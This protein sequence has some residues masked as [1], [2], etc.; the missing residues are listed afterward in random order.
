MALVERLPVGPDTA[1][2]PLWSTTARV[3]VSDVRSDAGLVAEARRITERVC[4][5]VD[6]AASRFRPD[7]EIHWVAANAGDWVLVSPLL[8]ELVRVSLEAAQRT[9][10]LVDPTVADAM[11]RLGYDR[12]I[13]RLRPESS[14]TRGVRVVARR[15]AGWRSVRFDGHHVQ[16]PEGVSLDLGATAKAWAADESARQVAEG[17]G[18]GV[19]VSLGGD[20]ATA[21]VARQGH[22][23]IL[24]SDG[25]GQPEA[26]V[27]LPAGHALATSST[28]SRTWRRGGQ[29]MHH[30]LDPRT[31]LPAPTVWR[32]VS[33]AAPTCVQAN[34]LTTAAVVRGQGAIPWLREQRVTARLVSAGGDVVRVGGWP[35]ERAA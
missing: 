8:A 7:A 23:S 22:W 25:P 24:V 18:V 35:Q 6:R 12:D 26:H 11:Q 1:Q 33:V 9:D 20:I 2:W 15:S 10:G 34:T 13:S 21:G 31:S 30:V 5:E 19:L 16:L 4:A 32:T 3:V 28:I 14:A 17:L 29:S 27:S